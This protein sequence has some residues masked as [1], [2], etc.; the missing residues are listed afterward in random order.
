MSRN[1]LI[2][3][4]HA[5]ARIAARKALQDSM[6]AENEPE[7]PSGSIRLIVRDNTN[8]LKAVVE[9]RLTLLAVLSTYVVLITLAVIVL[10]LLRLPADSLELV[11]AIILFIL[12]TLFLCLRIEYGFTNYRIKFPSYYANHYL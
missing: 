4:L 1:S 2:A 7:Y 10:L 3:S 9:T 5:A 8:W 11:S 6:N 12:M